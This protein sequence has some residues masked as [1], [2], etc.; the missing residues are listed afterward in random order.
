MAKAKTTEGSKQDSVTLL[1][2]VVEQTSG[3]ALT[4]SPKIEGKWSGYL[5]QKKQKFEG[6]SLTDVCSQIVEYIT[7]NRVPVEAKSTGKNQKPY[8]LA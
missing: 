1:E 2:T 8:K 7:A 4:L 5:L 3:T 6:E